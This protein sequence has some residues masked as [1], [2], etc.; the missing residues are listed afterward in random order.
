MIDGVH[1]FG[2][3]QNSVWL[4]NERRILNTRVVIRDSD[5]YRLSDMGLSV[6]YFAVFTS[7]PN[8]TS[9]TVPVLLSL[10]PSLRFHL[11][12]SR[13]TIPDFHSASS[14]ASLIFVSCC[15]RTTMISRIFSTIAIFSILG[16]FFYNLRTLIRIFVHREIFFVLR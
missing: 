2:P 15:H 13:C 8:K 10:A 9:K 14:L 7:P 16:F 5:S 3:K 1:N 4:Q 11:L 6:N 12:P